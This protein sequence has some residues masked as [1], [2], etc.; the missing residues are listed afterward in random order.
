MLLVGII[1]VHHRRGLRRQQV[2][3]PSKRANDDFPEQKATVA[4]AFNKAG[5][6]QF[7]E[8]LTD[9]KQ[10]VASFKPISSTASAPGRGCAVCFSLGGLVCHCCSTKDDSRGSTEPMRSA[11]LF[12]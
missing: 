8:I 3:L 4:E 10:A 12:V 2:I 6:T 1:D 9:L 7:I 5:F 11:A